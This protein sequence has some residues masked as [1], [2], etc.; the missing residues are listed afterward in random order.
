MGPWGP[1]RK[2]VILVDNGVQSLL[3]GLILYLHNSLCC[4][5][6]LWL[7]PRRS[8]Y[9]HT[10][11]LPPFLVLAVSSLCYAKYNWS[12]SRPIRS[13]QAVSCPIRYNRMASC[14]IRYNRT[15]VICY[16]YMYVTSSSW[17]YHVVTYIVAYN[18]RLQ[19]IRR[20]MVHMVCKYIA[21]AWQQKHEDCMIS[22]WPVRSL[23]D[24]HNRKWRY[25][26]S[27][28]IYST[29]PIGQVPNRVSLEEDKS[30]D[31]SIFLM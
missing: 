27:L 7:L 23:Y 16:C 30:R 29:S 2:G 11:M 13:N 31:P 22:R 17:E 6:G 18:R 3:T 28:V 9:L 25:T 20:C 24:R 5:P 8:K 15:T 14:P 19:Q 1:F 4:C 12:T 26:S 10:I 21:K